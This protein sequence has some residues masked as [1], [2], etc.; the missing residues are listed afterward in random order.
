MIHFFDSRHINRR[1]CKKTIMKIL[2]KSWISWFRQLE[3]ETLCLRLLFEKNNNPAN[4]Y[5]S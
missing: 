2:F 1:D 5:K 4:P 3:K